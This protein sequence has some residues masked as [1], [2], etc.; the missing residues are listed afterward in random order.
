MR[1][2]YGENFAGSTQAAAYG[3]SHQPRRRQSDIPSRRPRARLGADRGRGHWPARGR[4]RRLQ[5]RCRSDLRA[6]RAGALRRVHHRGDVRA[7]GVPPRRARRRDRKTPALGRAVSRARASGRRLFARQGAARDRAVAPGRLR[8][9]GLSARRHGEDHA[10]LRKP[11]HRARRIAA[12]Q[13]RHQAKPRRHHHHLPAVGVERSVDAP[14]PRSARRLRLGLDAGA[15]AGAAAGRVAAAGDL[16]SRRL[17]RPHRDHRRHR[18]RRDLGH[19]RPGGR[20]G[21]L[22]RHARAQSAA[23]RHRRLWR[24]GR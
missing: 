13:R 6:V 21:A 20:A 10:L 7:A 23:A 11:R 3:E 14:L 22:V 16:R 19:P 17:G 8:R 18:R 5:E 1:L 9:P 24:R 4:L 15:R 12:G 2:R